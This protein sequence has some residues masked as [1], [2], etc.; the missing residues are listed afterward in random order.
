MTENLRYGADYSVDRIVTHLDF[1]EDQ[2]FD[3]SVEMC[4]GAGICLKMGSGTMCPSFMATREEEHSTRG[5]ANALRA[6]LSGEIESNGLADE[7]LY[8]TMDLCLEC[9]A[10]ASECP[11][12]VD[13]TKLKMEFLAHYQS[14]HGVSRRSELFAN[15]AHSNRR[16]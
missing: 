1:S 7:R 15:I 2:G 6:V 5:R 9:K 12:S 16:C 11:S 3:R 4:N 10:C 14:S 13:M 8:E